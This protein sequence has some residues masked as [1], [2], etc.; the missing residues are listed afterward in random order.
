MTMTYS[1]KAVQLS[2]EFFQKGP[3]QPNIVSMLCEQ[4]GRE[5]GAKSYRNMRTS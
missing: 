3:Q 1:R 4:P 2:S 5:K